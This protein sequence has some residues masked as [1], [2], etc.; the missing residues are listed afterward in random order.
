MYLHFN[1][2]RHDCY[3]MR[4]IF[5]FVYKVCIVLNV[6][7]MALQYKTFEIENK[8]VQ[9]KNICNLRPTLVSFIFSVTA[10]FILTFQRK[11]ISH[12]K[13]RASLSV[14]LYIYTP[15]RARLLA[16]ITTNLPDVSAGTHCMV[17]EYWLLYCGK[18][19]LYVLAQRNAFYSFVVFPPLFGIGHHYISL[20]H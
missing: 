17:E 11:L 4:C 1:V 18:G 9:K 20:S 10:A 6:L 2:N 5:E 3:S 7:N 8:V 14:Y 13:H 16:G 12:L 19:F 15:K